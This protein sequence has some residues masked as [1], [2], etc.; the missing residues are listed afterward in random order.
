MKNKPMT[1]WKTVGAVLTA[2]LIG[3]TVIAI[4]YTALMLYLTK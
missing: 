4:P 1:F 2:Q 3:T